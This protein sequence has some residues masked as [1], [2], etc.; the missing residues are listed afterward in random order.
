MAILQNGLDEYLQNL[1]PKRD[2]ILQQ[3]EKIAEKN[4]FPIVGPQVGQVLMQ[5]ARLT[6][7]QRIFELGSGYGYSAMWWH[8]ATGEDSKIFC[9]D[10]DPENKIQAM[11][12]FARAGV[13]PGKIQFLVGD[14]I[15]QLNSVEGDFDIIYNDV[16]KEGYPD[17]FHAA[18]PRLRKGGLLITDNTLWYGKV[19]DENP[20]EA[21]RGVIE[22]NRLAFNDERV[23]S[24][25]LPIRDGL[26]VSLKL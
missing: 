17:V 2:E 22:Y 3:M 21:T 10:G 20:D 12:Y 4:E 24:M 6:K 13:S 9:T 19:I 18:V 16:D 15:T 1:I 26:C 7:A 14:A 23:L 5:Y 11:E 8:K 25:I